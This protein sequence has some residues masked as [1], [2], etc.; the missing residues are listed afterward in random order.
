M[1]TRARYFSRPDIMRLCGSLTDDNALAIETALATGLRVSDILHLTK[2]RLIP[3]DKIFFVARKT[4]KKG[5]KVID[6]RLFQRLLRNG[7]R[8]FVFPN[9]RDG[10]RT[11]TRQAVWS[12]MRRAYGGKGRAPS[13][14]SARQAYAVA[15][16]REQGID[17]VKRELQHSHTDTTLAYALADVMQ[18]RNFQ[19]DVD[20]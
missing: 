14:H 3:P 15:L 5:V 13:P 12:N 19:Q 7:N 20:N 16:A 9:R 17:A 6:K 10:R 8:K 2:E 11:R 4:G 18:A 1:G